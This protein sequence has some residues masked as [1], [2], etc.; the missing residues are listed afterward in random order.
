MP[1]DHRS[2]I[3]DSRASVVVYSFWIFFVGYGLCYILA[4]IIFHCCILSILLGLLTSIDFM[5]CSPTLSMVVALV[6]SEARSI[7]TCRL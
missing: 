6:V 2:H 5:G 4:S 7:E 3:L 1:S